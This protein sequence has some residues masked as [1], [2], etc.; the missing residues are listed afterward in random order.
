MLEDF[1]R[2][3]PSFLPVIPTSPWDTLSIA[4]HHGL[5][6]RLLDWTKNPLAALWFAVRET[7][8]GP[9]EP[10]VWAFAPPDDYVIRNVEGAPSPFEGE[11]TL[12]FEPRHV[13]A[14][15]RAQE[16]VFTVHK[17]LHDRSDGFVAL[18][19]N[20]T[21]TAFLRKVQIDPSSIQSIRLELRRCGVHGSSLFPD[22][23]GLARRIHDDTLARRTRL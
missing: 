10:T 13:T 19:R 22:L 2:E 5:P 3:L 18:E 20:K 11:R 14:R 7:D 6:T 23:D 17:Y 12:A 4:Q 21:Y 15:I 9:H 8:Q 16:G 1:L